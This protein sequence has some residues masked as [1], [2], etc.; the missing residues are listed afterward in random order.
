[1]TVKNNNSNLMIKTKNK[2]SILG[3]VG[4]S[5]D[6]EFTLVGDSI[7]KEWVDILCN[8]GENVQ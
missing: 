6:C 3:N 7:I 4:E 1:M 8:R 5:V 2:Y